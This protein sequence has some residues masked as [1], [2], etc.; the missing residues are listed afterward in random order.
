LVRRVADSCGDLIFP[1]SEDEL[2]K[3][4]EYLLESIIQVSAGDIGSYNVPRGTTRFLVWD[5]DPERLDKI[6]N[7]AE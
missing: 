4:R 3:S 6:G 7:Q 2:R 1:G 5:A